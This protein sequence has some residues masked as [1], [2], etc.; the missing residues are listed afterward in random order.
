MFTEHSIVQ[1]FT[2]AALVGFHYL[3]YYAAQFLTLAAQV[4][5][6]LHTRCQRAFQVSVQLI[7]Y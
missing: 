7:T 2:T 4:I 6:A 5:T 1:V 3:L